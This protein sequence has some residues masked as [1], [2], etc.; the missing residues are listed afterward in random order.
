MW[1]RNHL[2]R[3]DHPTKADDIYWSAVLGSKGTENTSVHTIFQYMMTKTHKP[4]SLGIDKS[5]TKQNRLL[6]V[7]K[8]VIKEPQ[9]YKPELCAFLEYLRFSI[10]Y[11]SLINTYCLV[12]F[13]KV[14]SKFPDTKTLFKSFTYQ[15]SKRDTSKISEQQSKSSNPNATDSVQL[16]Q[17]S[18]QTNSEKEILNSNS[19][20]ST[21]IPQ[22]H[23]SDVK[24]STITNLLKN[25]QTY[26]PSVKDA[27]KDVECQSVV[28]C[29]HPYISY[30]A[31]AIMFILVVYLIIVFGKCVCEENY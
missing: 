20:Q 8:D 10:K 12:A 4:S 11:K 22:Q 3:N 6:Y 7:G 1:Q 2:I 26:A 17:I 27:E 31:G 18:P 15:R 5:L 23:V 25:R 13:S 9:T 21:T 30:I 28:S 14:R 24:T 19:I 16:L 29:V